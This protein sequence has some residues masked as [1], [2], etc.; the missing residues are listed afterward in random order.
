MTFLMAQLICNGSP[1]FAVGTCWLFGIRTRKRVLPLFG[2]NRT[3][4]LAGIRLPDAVLEHLS[5]TAN[6][7][8]TSMPLR[9]HRRHEN[10]HDYL[11]RVGWRL[12]SHQR[13]PEEQRCVMGLPTSGTTLG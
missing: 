9:A 8:E 3:Q 12:F 13:S 2:P 11:Y 7:E 6:P 5:S 10:S 4:R 1:G